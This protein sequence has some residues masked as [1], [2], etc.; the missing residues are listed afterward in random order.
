M[1]DTSGLATFQNTRDWAQDWELTQRQN[2]ACHMSTAKNAVPMWPVPICII[3]HLMTSPNLGQHSSRLQLKKTGGKGGHT[4][5]ISL[6]CFSNFSA[7]F[8]NGLNNKYKYIII[9]LGCFSNFSAHFKNGLNNK[10]KY[11][12]ISLVC[13]SNFSF[14][15][16]IILYIKSLY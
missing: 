11:I 14:C 6:G 16:A 7:H 15:W 4:L 1:A 2:G 10:Y 3:Y 5:H 13:F 12:I 8:K 9:S